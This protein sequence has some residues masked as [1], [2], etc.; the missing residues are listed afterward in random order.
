MRMIM[1]IRIPVEHGN[2]AIQD[3]SMTRAFENPFEIL[4]PEAAYFSMLDGSRAVL[5][6]SIWLMPEG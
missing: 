6:T 2:R 5:N 3:G 4:Q 1:T